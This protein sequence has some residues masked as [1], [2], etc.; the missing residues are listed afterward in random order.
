MGFYSRGVFV[1]GSTAFFNPM[2]DELGW[3]YTAVSLAFSIRGFEEGILAPVA[4]IFVDRLGPRRLLL[5]GMIIMGSGYLFLSQVHSLQSFYAAFVILALGSSATSVVVTMT[6]VARWFKK[7]LGQAASFT[8]AGYGA[9]GMLVPGIVWLIAQ[10][11]WREATV[12]LG[13]AMW[14]IGIPLSLVVRD[15]PEGRGHPPDEGTSASVTETVEESGLTAKEAFKKREFWLLWL[16]VGFAHVA[17]VAVSTHQIP[18]LTSLGISR[19]V[20][21]LTVVVL[22]SSNLVGRLGFGWLGDTFDTRYCFAIAAAI[23]AVGVFAFSRAHILSQFI[24]SLVMIGIGHG[25]TAPLRPPLQVGLFGRKAFGTV[26]GVLVIANTVGAIGSPVFAGWV[27]DSMGTYRP[28]WFILAIVTLLAVPSVLA[29][30][31]PE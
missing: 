7:K 30:K 28:A 11:G 31:K 15:R 19:E 17:A 14:V 6:A 18:Y 5:F 26:Q 23:K 21:S 25:G 12:I 27:F 1:Y 4:G 10:Y 9:S 3:T 20:A 13:V 2:V 22:A 16:A 24:V 29:I 8:M